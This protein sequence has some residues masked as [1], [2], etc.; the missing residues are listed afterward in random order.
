MFSHAALH[1]KLM[2]Y[3]MAK[4]VREYAGNG[5][6]FARWVGARAVNHVMKYRLFQDT[7]L[8][9]ASAGLA[10]NHNLNRRK[11]KEKRI[12]SIG[13]ADVDR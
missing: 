10:Q 4:C 9:G 13:R 12:N 2:A 8:Y 11:P 7:A 5:P 1:T 3:S 6:I